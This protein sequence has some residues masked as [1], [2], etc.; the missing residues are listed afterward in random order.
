MKEGD[1]VMH[2]RTRAKHNKAGELI[3][4]HLAGHVG[5]VQS[6][7]GSVAWLLYPGDVAPHAWDVNDL[8]VISQEA[9]CA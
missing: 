7:V 3:G 9:I 8:R 4:L 1:C 2:L 6:V 5:H